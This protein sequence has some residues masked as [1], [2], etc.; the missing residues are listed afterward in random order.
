MNT[1]MI[2][3][4]NH[5]PIY[6]DVMYLVILLVVIAT[7]VFAFAQLRQSGNGWSVGRRMKWPCLLWGILAVL[8]FLIPRVQVVWHRLSGSSLMGLETGMTPSPLWLQMAPLALYLLGVAVLLGS[9]VVFYRLPKHGESSR[10]WVVMGSACLI[11]GVLLFAVYAW[12][13]IRFYLA[14]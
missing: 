7:C 5:T 1:P 14:F 13:M 6:P 4:V 2:E 3:A 10:S 11:S 8:L 12:P 9:A